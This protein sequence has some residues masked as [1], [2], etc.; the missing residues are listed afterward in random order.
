MVLC[1]S[2]G[3]SSGTLFGRRCSISAFAAHISSVCSPMHQSNAGVRVS[4]G[5]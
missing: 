3:K 1:T 5:N 2:R 4:Y